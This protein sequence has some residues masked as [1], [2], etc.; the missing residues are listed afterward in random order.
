[1]SC[2][3]VFTTVGKLA[4]AQAISRALVERKLAACAQISEIESVYVW[5]GAVQ[6]EKEFRILLKTTRERYAEVETAIRELHPYDL[7]AVFSVPFDQ[8]YPPFADWV[9]EGSSGGTSPG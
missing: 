2:I 8:V 9:M 5:N 3:A 4:E 7:P 1:M 6:N